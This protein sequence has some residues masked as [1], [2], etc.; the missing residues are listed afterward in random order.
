[1][2]CGSS[3]CHEKLNRCCLYRTTS[4]VPFRWT[5]HRSLCVWSQYRRGE[6]ALG[7][8]RE[9]RPSCLLL[10]LPMGVCPLFCPVFPTTVSVVTGIPS[11][12]MREHAFRAIPTHIHDGTKCAIGSSSSG[13]TNHTVISSGNRAGHTH[14]TGS[15]AQHSPRP[16]TNVAENKNRIFHCAEKGEQK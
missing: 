16:I 11:V 8:R 4:G 5:D 9:C 15:V 13:L 10:Q 14:Y 2:S 12:C 7:V 6:F 3:L 1:M